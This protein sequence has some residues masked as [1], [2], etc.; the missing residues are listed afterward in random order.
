MD[1]APEV[2]R[3]PQP[4]CDTAPCSSKQRQTGLSSLGSSPT[5][6]LSDS[7]GRVERGW[8]ESDG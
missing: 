6:R 3:H 5:V 7:M 2:G 1:N 4:A 8:C